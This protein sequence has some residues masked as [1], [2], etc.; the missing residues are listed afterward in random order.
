M[1]IRE[2]TFE[3]MQARGIRYIFGN[4]GSTELPFL[5]NLPDGVRWMCW[6]WAGSPNGQRGRTCCSSS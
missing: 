6:R 1:N 4:P 5:V 2:A 3:W